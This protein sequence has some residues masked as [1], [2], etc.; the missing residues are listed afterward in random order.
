MLGCALGPGRTGFDSPQ[1]AVLLLA[2]AAVLGRVRDGV[3][4]LWVVGAVMDGCGAVGGLGDGSVDGSGEDTTPA[5]Q[6]L[7]IELLRL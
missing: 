3:I 5:V 6:G 2:L 7:F 4:V 1:L